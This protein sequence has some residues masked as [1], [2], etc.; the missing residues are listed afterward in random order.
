MAERAAMKAVT[1]REG[2][3]SFFDLLARVERGEKVLITREGRPVAVLS[4]YRSAEVAPEREAARAHA[5][6]SWR[7]GCRGA[8]ASGCTPGTRCMSADGFSPANEAL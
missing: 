2:A 8:R 5:L 4:P 1:V 7:L 3:R 6:A